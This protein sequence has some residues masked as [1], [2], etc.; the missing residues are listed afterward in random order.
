MFIFDI[1]LDV[2]I[3]S[4]LVFFFLGSFFDILLGSLSSLN[5]FPTFDFLHCF[6][7]LLILFDQ[8]SKILK[9]YFLSPFFDFLLEWRYFIEPVIFE[10]LEWALIQMYNL[11][12]MGLIVD[13]EVWLHRFIFK[14]AAFFTFEFPFS[15]GECRLNLHPTN[16]LLHSRIN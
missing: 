12:N 13:L 10:I 4:F 9:L 1:L 11:L 15:L 16:I 3:F 5:I 8:L 7:F 2:E 14:E 6:C